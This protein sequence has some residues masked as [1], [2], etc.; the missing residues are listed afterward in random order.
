[1]VSDGTETRTVSVGFLPD[2]G[3]LAVLWDGRWAGPIPSVFCSLAGLLIPVRASSPGHRNLE[4]LSMKRA[5][6]PGQ[7]PGRC[8][9]LSLA[10][11]KASMAKGLC[12]HGCP[13]TQSG[14]GEG[15]GLPTAMLLR[16]PVSRSKGALPF[17]HSHKGR[18]GLW[19]Q[20]LGRGTAMTNM[21]EI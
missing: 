12:S 17:L 7:L 19:G 2:H 16:L 3:S 4:F 1:M 13:H 5:A 8:S 9:V 14:R 15:A 21:S 11:L 6:V 20:L 10:V 18:V